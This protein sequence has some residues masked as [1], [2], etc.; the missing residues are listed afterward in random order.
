M[1]HTST[2]QCPTSW[3]AE[4]CIGNMLEPMGTPAGGGVDLF[5]RNG[6]VGN[7]LPPATGM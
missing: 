6:K 4:I 7:F 2:H 3:H 1:K 5:P